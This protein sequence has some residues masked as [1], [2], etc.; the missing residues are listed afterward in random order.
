M[1]GHGAHHDAA[2][3]GSYAA[4]VS[5][6]QGRGSRPNTSG[7]NVPRTPQSPRD[8]PAPSGTGLSGGLSSAR[9]GRTRLSAAA[10]TLADRL[11]RT[12]LS[13]SGSRANGAHAADPRPPTREGASTSR[14]GRRTRGEATA[15]RDEVTTHQSLED[16]LLGPSTP[17]GSDF[18]PLDI[19]ED[20]TPTES[21]I[22]DGDLSPSALPISRFGHDLHS[23]PFSGTRHDLRPATVSVQMQ[24]HRRRISSGTLPSP[25]GVHRDDDSAGGTREV[26]LSSLSA[27]L[28]SPK[29]HAQGRSHSAR[30]AGEAGSL[31]QDRP[32]SRQRPP[33]ESLHL[34][35]IG[36]RIDT[37]VGYSKNSAARPTTSHVVSR[38]GRPMSGPGG[39]GR[40]PTR[41]R[42]GDHPM[43]ERRPP[44]QQR[45]PDASRDLA[46]VRGRQL[47]ASRSGSD[48]SGAL[49]ATRPP[50]TERQA[51]FHDIFGGDSDGE[52]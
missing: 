22:D 48:G 32:P 24:G 43:L 47:T 10:D 50:A 2:P 29:P 34:F 13:R 31:D 16:Y 28:F 4:L 39:S 17:G 45:L 42:G 40:P 19:P 12:S 8:A 30:N 21:S 49:G 15:R 27:E 18:A 46:A 1:Q 26:D 5:S 33:P 6:A 7:A 14:R 11:E 25:R 35:G 37:S 36:K 51:I 41:D 44:P 9:R 38:P 20:P 52:V 23:I 3:A